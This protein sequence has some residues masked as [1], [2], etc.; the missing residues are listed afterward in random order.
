GSCLVS[1]AVKHGTIL[2]TRPPM[3][4]VRIFGED[5]LLRGVNSLKVAPLKMG[6]EVL[7]A[8]VFGTEKRR[9]LEHADVRTLELLASQVAQ[10]LQRARYYAQAQALADK[11]GLT[12][13][14]NRRV[15]EERLA[16]M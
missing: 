10:S 8:L 9:H 11:D 2:P 12:G 15:F 3:K 5:T 6:S 7:G 16:H 1:Q 13:L 4:P 14:A